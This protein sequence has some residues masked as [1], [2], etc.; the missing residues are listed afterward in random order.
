[1]SNR[2]LRIAAYILVVIAAAVT[3]VKISDRSIERERI[4][5][6]GACE[7]VQILRDQANGTNLLI[8]TTFNDV[9]AQQKGILKKASDPKIRAQ[10]QIAL[11]RAISVVKTTVVTGPTNCYASVYHPETYQP[12]APQL[13]DEGGLRIKIVRKRAQ[14]IVVY[15]KKHRKFPPILNKNGK[16][17]TEL[18]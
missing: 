11:D 10:A 9:A 12:P 14:A 5:Q 15:A 3:V 17:I 2:Y 1:M 13:I 6:I 18:P 16:P 8:Y 4:A 7:R